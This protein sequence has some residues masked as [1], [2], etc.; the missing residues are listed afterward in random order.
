MQTTK[1]RS[2]TQAASSPMEAELMRLRSALVSLLG[3]DD[4][5]AYRPA[6]VA[7]ILKAT[8]EKPERT[9]KGAKNFLEDLRR[10]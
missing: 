3:K 7:R 1:T 5:G 6:F 10:A 4:E 8:T 2:K 9:F